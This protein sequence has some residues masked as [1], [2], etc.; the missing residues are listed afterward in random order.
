MEVEME[1]KQQL[2]AQLRQEI[3]IEMDYIQ[4]TQTHSPTDSNEVT[5]FS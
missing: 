1:L 5:H 4:G 2:I 3:S